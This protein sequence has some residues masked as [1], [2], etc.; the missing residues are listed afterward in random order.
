MQVKLSRQ[1]HPFRLLG[2]DLYHRVV[3]NFHNE[4][5]LCGWASRRWEKEVR[6]ITP[7]ELIANRMVVIN[8]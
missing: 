1:G 2:R 6:P 5:G 3:Q 7:S 4:V 8:V